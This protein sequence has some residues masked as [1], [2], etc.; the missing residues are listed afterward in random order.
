[1]KVRA[2]ICGIVLTGTLVS[3][4]SVGLGITGRKMRNK[5]NPQKNSL[6]SLTLRANHEKICQQIKNTEYK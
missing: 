2:L 4:G 5:N 6:D 1:M 3:A